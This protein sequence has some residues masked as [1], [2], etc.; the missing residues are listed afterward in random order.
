MR[1]DRRALGHHLPRRLRRRF[2]MVRGDMWKA[3][4][5]IVMRNYESGVRGMW[6]AMRTGPTFYQMMSKGA[7]K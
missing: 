3:V 1:Q 5:K 2:L 4:D 7:S 6:D